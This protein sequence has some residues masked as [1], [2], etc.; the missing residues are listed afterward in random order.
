M[1][2]NQ[3]RLTLSLSAIAG[4]LV[5]AAFLPMAVALADDFDFTPDTT[6]FD[7]AQV[8][9]GYP[10]LVNVVN[11]TEDWNLNDL[12]TNSVLSSDLFSGEETETTI[13]S[14]SNDNLLLGLPV[15]MSSG[16]GLFTFTSGTEIDFANFG[17]G[18][19]NDWVDIPNGPDA[20][21][22]DLVI[23]PL[24]DLQVLGTAFADITTLLG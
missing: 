3:C 16:N 12:T 20:G 2:T 19:E 7:P 22:S 1:K 11:G 24:G 4:G 6:T 15:V 14:F 17:G 5:A 21:I 18:F 9:V 10:P 13:G 8:V 23:T